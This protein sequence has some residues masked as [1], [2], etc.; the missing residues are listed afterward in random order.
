MININII[1]LYPHNEAMPLPAIIISSYLIG[2]TLTFGYRVNKGL[3]ADEKLRQLYINDMQT[4][5]DK[6]EYHKQPLRTSRLPEYMIGG[7]LYS[8]IWPV[9]WSSHSYMNWHKA[10]VKAAYEAAVVARNNKRKSG[11]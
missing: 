3:A 9:Y 8:A 4:H 1:C 10:P 6:Y 5:V 11:Q 7:V 2:A